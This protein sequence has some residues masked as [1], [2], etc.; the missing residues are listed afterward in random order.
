MPAV[1]VRL[2]PQINFN[3][4]EA[5]VNKG[6]WWIPRHSEAMKGVVTNEIP[7]GVGNKLRSGGSR[8]RKLFKLFIEYI[9][10]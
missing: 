6:L 10:K 8:M 2:P 7:R 4:I 3:I 5:Q 1:R 9:N